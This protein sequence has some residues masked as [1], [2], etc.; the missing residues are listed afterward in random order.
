ME[1]DVI[2]SVPRKPPS[3]RQSPS[4]AW[5]RRRF[6]LQALLPVA[7]AAP[8]L[9]RAAA[10][11]AAKS[12]PGRGVRETAN[13][14]GDSGSGSGSVRAASDSDNRLATAVYING[15]G[16]YRFLV[17]TGDERTPIG[18]EIA[19]Q[20]ALPRGRKVMVEGITRGQPAELVKVASRRMGRLVCPSL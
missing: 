11:P 17:D 8:A 18:A 19:A 20:L 4:A 13:G 12:P 14:P 9:V 1:G 3:G 10:M 7:A 5:S 16:P 15:S 2:I 6:M